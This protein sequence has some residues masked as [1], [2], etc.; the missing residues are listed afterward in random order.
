ML[1]HGIGTSHHYFAGLHRVLARTADTWSV[2]LP[3][4][5]GTPKP[6]ASP[7]VHEMAA[8]LGV[9]LDH[10]GGPPFVLIGHSMGAQWAVELARARPDLVAAV[11][12][13][14]PVVDRAHRSLRAQ[15]LA[16]L[17]DACKEPPRVNTLAVMAYLR[18]GPRHFLRQAKQMKRYRTEAAVSELS[19]PILVVRGAR[20]PV[21][22]A[23][24][25][26]ELR[27]VASDGS[28]VTVPGRAHAVHATAPRTVARA[29]RA[30]VRE[31]VAGGA[32]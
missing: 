11:V 14:G 26:R 24:W 13:I 9:V 7:T 1:I 17:V 22:G 16:L 28:L 31:R 19:V 23:R 6:A 12:L 2:D 20:D 32:T 8:A 18:C 3:G 15:L 29:V 30:F 4:F 10:W 27:D 25:V 21:A 5:G